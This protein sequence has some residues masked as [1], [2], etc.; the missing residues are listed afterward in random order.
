METVPKFAL[1]AVLLSLSAFFSCAG[2]AVFSL[3]RL[4]LG[5]LRAQGG[6]LRVWAAD[7]RRRSDALLIAVRLGNTAVNVLYFSVAAVIAISLEREGFFLAGVAFSVAAFFAVV[8]FGEVIPQTV[9]VQFPR[10]VSLAAALPLTVFVASLEPLRSLLGTLDRTFYRIVTRR[11]PPP[12]HLTEDEIRA[13]IQ[14]GQ[15]EGQLDRDEGRLIRESLE[16]A[17]VTVKHIMVPRVDIVAFPVT[18]KREDLIAQGAA[19]KKTKVPVYEGSRDHVVGIVKVKNL[20]L[21]PDKELRSLVEPILFVPESMA[22]AEL[23]RQFIEQHRARAIVVDEYGGTEGLVT[24]EDVLEEIVGDIRDEYDTTAPAYR[25]VAE[26]VWD[27]SGSLSVREWAPVLGGDVASGRIRTFSGYIT[28]RLGRV[29][30]KDDVVRQGNLELRVL[31][32]GRRR[33]GRV[34]IRFHPPGE[35][36]AAEEEIRREEEKS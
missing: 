27:L 31:E 17:H 36:P 34:R 20:Y 14:L 23:M 1:L 30:R 11:I 35:E 8:L 18:G 13:L 19:T 5:R 24:L 32:C 7:L 28:A 2:T 26:G 6:R 16:L 22:A 10:G 3:S 12:P 9:A 15:Q 4:D 33:V 25:K 21:Y 29:P